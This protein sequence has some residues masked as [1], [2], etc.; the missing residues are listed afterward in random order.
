MPQESAEDSLPAL[1]SHADVGENI[2]EW[3]AALRLGGIGR[4]LFVYY[5]A[6][7][8][9]VAFCRAPLSYGYATIKDT[10]PLGLRALTLGSLLDLLSV[11]P[12]TWLR[13]TTA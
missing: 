3:D 10:V 5:V 8:T 11:I 1:L 9:V 4:K 6:S 7:E 2:L 12:D 13:V